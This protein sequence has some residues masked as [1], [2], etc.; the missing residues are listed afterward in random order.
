MT[1]LEALECSLGQLFE[2]VLMAPKDADDKVNVRYAFIRRI[3]RSSVSKGELEAL[4]E[5]LVGANGEN[6]FWLQSRIR[7]RLAQKIY[8]PDHSTLA[9]GG[10]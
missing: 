1:V 9:L 8:R 10:P 5:R 2:A 7:D 6:A 4:A 3:G